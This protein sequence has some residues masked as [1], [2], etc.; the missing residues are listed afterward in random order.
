M[1]EAGFAERH[2]LVVLC[3]IFLIGFVYAVSVCGAFAFPAWLFV[4]GG[5]DDFPEYLLCHGNLLRFVDP[6]NPQALVGFGL[7]KCVVVIFV[8]LKVARQFRH[9]HCS[10]LAFMRQPWW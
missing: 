1:V 7:A 4:F 6:Q 8:P 10:S 3:V 2:E 5:S 9:C